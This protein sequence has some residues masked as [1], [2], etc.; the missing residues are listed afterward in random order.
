V[1][2]FSGPETVGFKTRHGSMK[3]FRR[4]AKKRGMLGEPSPGVKACFASKMKYREYMDPGPLQRRDSRVEQNG[5]LLPPK[6][7]RTIRASRFRDS[8]S[9]KKG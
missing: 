3:C 6:A 5:V 9:Y 2:D 4:L 1:A 8:L 7:E